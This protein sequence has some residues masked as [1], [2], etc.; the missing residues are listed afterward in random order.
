M[1][2]K[3]GNEESSGYQPLNLKKNEENNGGNELNSLLS[4]LKKQKLKIDNLISDSLNK[5]KNSW[6]D[7]KLFALAY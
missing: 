5:K 4:E 6:Q 1:N 3:K 7:L 2:S